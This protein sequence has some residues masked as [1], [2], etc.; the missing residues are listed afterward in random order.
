MRKTLFHI[1]SLVL[2][3]AWG[4][5][6]AYGVNDE[7]NSCFTL[8]IDAGHGGHDTGAPGKKSSEKHINLK[9]ALAFGRLVE[10]N[11]KDVRVIYTR[12]TDVFIPLM[13]RAAIANDAKAD[14]FIS[15]H[16]NSLP[17]GRVAY[18]S[19]TYTLGMARAQSNLDVA[20]RENSV[21]TLE[22]DYKKTYKGFDPNKAE[23]YVIF[24]FMQDRNMKQS[25]DLASCI[26]KQYAAVGRPNRGVHQAGFLVLR[27]TSMPS[28]L[29]ELGFINTS[30]EESYLISQRGVEELSR[31]LYN[32]F[33]A[34]RRKYDK[35]AHDLP[36]N[37]P[38][39]VETVT[40]RQEATKEPAP[41]VRQ[42]EQSAVEN[43]KTEEPQMVRESE[44]Q[45]EKQSAADAQLV[46]H[47]QLCAGSVKASSSHPRYKGLP[48]QCRK[49]GAVYKYLYG[50]Y[51]TY[52]EAR[53][54]LKEAQTK[55]P[56]AY[57]IAFY[58]DELLTCAEARQREKK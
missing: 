51:A 20:R 17:K 49:V 8:V 47:V 40:A 31:C 1:L 32:G 50:S 56:G 39:R 42:P 13:R 28:V 41:S 22:K 16:T 37:L 33:L 24:E 15:V 53:K 18:G 14:L 44:P 11:C 26:Q 54:G 52:A 57:I 4:T 12:K 46:Y 2:L 19:E 45:P 58:G 10:K 21:I 27:E 35:R 43:H 48:I 3:M 5:H 38:T 29:T 7:R 55:V 9:V 23:S 6:R 34:Y 30:T 36:E 25:V